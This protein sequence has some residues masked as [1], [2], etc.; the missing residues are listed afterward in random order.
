MARRK[1]WLFVAITVLLIYFLAQTAT[2]AFM[3]FHDSDGPSGEWLHR[4]ALLHPLAAQP[5]LLLGFAELELGQ[6]EQRADRLTAAVEHLKKAIQLN[7]FVYQAH[8]NLGKAYLLLSESEPHRV[9]DG[10]VSFKRAARIRGANLAVAMDTARLFFSLWPL[11]KAQDQ[12]FARNLVLGI[13]HRISHKDFSELVELWALYNRKID[14]IE[15][16]VARRPEYSLLVAEALTRNRSYNDQ[17]RRLLN[18]H[19]HI[20]YQTIKRR[21]EEE[22]NKAPLSQNSEQL[23]KLFNELGK[24]YRRYDR[25]LELEL[26]P[27]KT[28][29]AL[30]RRLGERLL[31]MLIDEEGKWR[32]PKTRP[33]VDMVVSELIR[34]SRDYE[35]VFELEEQLSK[36][37]YYREGDLKSFLFQQR[38]LLQTA[39][40][41]Q[42]ID[43]IETL[44]RQIS[45][46]REDARPDMIEALFLLCDAYRQSR[47]L[48]M[49]SKVLD[50][51]EPLSPPTERL[52]WQ[53][54]LIEKVISVSAD[55]TLIES[56]RN[57]FVASR[58]ITL[59]KKKE[60]RV[61]YLDDKLE[62]TIQL[63]DELWQKGSSD[64]AEIN[65]IE[66]FSADGRIL[67]DSYLGDENMFSFTFPDSYDGRA[68]E[69]EI[70]VR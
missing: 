69:L 29:F 41:D 1:Y 12:A 28:L 15:E 13:M 65:L 33:P 67:W 43:Q 19:D 54:Y 6:K 9:S 8:L 26:F 42:V 31:I 70:V 58:A 7:P 47:L 35:N 60:K 53:R 27:D 11:L 45:F 3:S 22:L 17:R 39:R 40:F 14:L 57:Q 21:A 64:E 25:L 16:F 23:L 52:L 37:G 62:I 18:T 55:A 30:R 4:A 68:L 49:A 51:L 66:L 32:A 44:Q 50:S 48:T 61:I 56:W 59:S 63:A 10:I 24:V 34:D 36:R 5:H 38:I 20:R 2:D 46:V